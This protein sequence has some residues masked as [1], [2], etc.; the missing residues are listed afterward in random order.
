MLIGIE[1]R[2][3]AF[4]FLNPT[5]KPTRAKKARKSQKMIP[6]ECKNRMTQKDRSIAFCDLGALSASKLSIAVRILA[7]L[8]NCLANSTASTSAILAP[9]SGERAH[10]MVG[11]TNKD[12][13]RFWEFLGVLDG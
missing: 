12:N 5:N 13:I 10:G 1:R 11:I 6:S 8:D 4:H 3:Y 9:V 7:Q 2:Y